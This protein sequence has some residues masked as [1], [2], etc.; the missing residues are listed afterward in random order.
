MVGSGQFDVVL[1]GAGPAG[2]VLARRLTEDAGRTVALVEAGPDYGVDPNAWPAVFRD[3]TVVAPDLHGW[4]YLHA[5]RPADR[6]LSLARARMVGGTSTIN[7]CVWLRGS[8]ADY[9]G[10]AARGNPGW[11]F[12]DLLPFFRRAETDPI[13]GPFHGGDGPVPV[14]RAAET[15]LT[16][17]DRA[18]VEAARAIGFPR[19][20]DFNGDAAQRPGVGPAPKNVEDGVR[21]N[22][23]FTYLAPVRSRPNLTLIP[24][25]LV[26][27]VCVEDGR[28]TGV[29]LAHGREVRGREVVLCAGAFGSPAILLRSG[30]GPAAELGRH[31]IGVVAE[32]AGVGESLLDHPLIVGLMECTIAPGY[33]PTA[34]TF[35]PII[36]KARSGQ[37]TDEID[38]H[39]YQGQSWDAGRGAWSFWFSVS[40]QQAFSRGRVRLT[41]P[42]PEA[43]LEID[44]AHL[45]DPHDR[46]ALCDGVELVNRL[47]ATPPLAGAVTPVPE[48]TMRW[49]DRDELRALVGA[50]PGTTF[51]PSGTCRMGPSDD[52]AAV[53]DQAGRVHGIGGL[54]VA[55]ASIFPTIPRANI[56]CTIVA[57]AEKIAEDMRRGGAPA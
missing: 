10:W 52:P 16:R 13:G 19:V 23:A 27:R 18:L 5:G 6:P 17:L 56:H 29:R 38:L 7:G 26:D 37:A 28:A 12:A 44:H 20:A 22:G 41:S 3:P 45:A 53:V 54:R 34:P 35:A 14:F 32:R 50:S 39:V 1:V 8:A 51:H 43:S 31:G 57:A 24:E 30:I 55:D 40:L 25:A 49:R 47:A 4:G 46:E 42:D 2:C 36:L 21:M 33:E 15:E 11:G 9:D 48:R